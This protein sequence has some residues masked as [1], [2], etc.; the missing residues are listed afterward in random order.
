MSTDKPDLT[1]VAR[2]RRALDS[3]AD[4]SHVLAAAGLS[5]ARWAELEEEVMNTLA[6]DVDRGDSTRLEAYRAAYTG[7]AAGPRAAASAAGAPSP[8]TASA[9]VAEPP[10]ISVAQPSKASY[11]RVPI[12]AAPI[13]VD[14]TA[15]VDVRNIVAGIRAAAGPF[16]ADAPV[17]KPMPVPIAPPEDQSGSTMTEDIS[18]LLRAA[19]PAVPFGARPAAPPA[20]PPPP[21]PPLPAQERPTSV[22]TEA[23][24]F[25]EMHRMLAK[26][27]T[28][29]P[30]AS[31]RPA[32]VATEAI[33]LEAVQRMLGTG[34]VPFSGTAAPPPSLP[35]RPPETSPMAYSVPTEEVRLAAAVALPF[36]QQGP[37]TVE[38]Y[39]QIQA[40]ITTDPDPGSVLGRFGVS[41]QDW[42]AVHTDMRARFKADPALRA[43]YE[44]LLREATK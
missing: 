1:L 28:P 32:S 30:A 21:P 31:E 5:D 35:V 26:G 36:E 23:V 12:P 43:R 34:P 19:G 44:Q 15:Q 40:A 10:A 39:A 11:Q 22:A 9:A 2:T 38:R 4:A 41:L 25:E 7:E 17:R 37:M 33:D 13:S 8:A 42:G 3:G 14:D 20:P 29:F 18:A 24:D 16:D 6:D 27:P